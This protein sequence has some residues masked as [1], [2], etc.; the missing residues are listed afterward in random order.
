MSARLG[1]D[2]DLIQAGGGNTSVKLHSNLWIKAS[3]TWLIHAD[4]DDIFLP[5]SLTAIRACIDR[6]EEYVTNHHG[7]RPSVEAAMHA[8]LPHL[9]VVHV[10][11]V[12][13]LAWAS[14][15]DSPRS[16][17]TR[18]EGL[19]WVWIPYIHPGLPLALSIRETLGSSPDVIVMQ[20]HGLIVAGDTCESAEALLH[21][22]ERRLRLH[23]RAHP[24]AQIDELRKL[25][26]SAWQL[27][28]DDGVHSLGTDPDSFRIATGGTLYPDHCVYLGHAVAACHSGQAPEDAAAR[29]ERQWGKRPAVL[30]CE[31]YGV[32]IAPDLSRA[33]REMLTCISSVVRRIPADAEVHYLPHDQV[34]RLMNW[35]A[36]HY[37]QAVARQM[38]RQ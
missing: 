33:G 7:L 2:P 27:P 35:D 24:P 4:R 12:N 6:N 37:R 9:C 28:A 19:K 31:G 20:N 8:V 13:T 5:V 3:G 18:L 21:D 16:F 36:E 11:S 34:S 1:R 25:A 23:M 17:A 10:H 30:A 29:Y 14:L 26:G 15:A 32:L 22:V 38:E